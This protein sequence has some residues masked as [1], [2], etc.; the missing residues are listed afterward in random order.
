MA[1]TYVDLALASGSNNGTSWA[2]A[3][4]TTTPIQN[5]LTDAGA[6][7]RCFVKDDAGA[8]NPDTGTSR[9]LTS[10]A[11]PYNITQLI[12]CKSGT[13]A[14]PPTDADVC[15]RGTDNLRTFL[16]T[17]GI[18]RVDNELVMIGIKFDTATDVTLGSDSGLVAYDCEFE[19]GDDIDVTGNVRSSPFIAR[20]CE[21]IFAAAGSSFSAGAGNKI[22]IIGGLISGTAPTNLVVNSSGAITFYGVDLS[23][24]SGSTFV[25]QD[26]SRSPVYTRFI[27]CKFP[28]SYS[29][30]TAPVGS[31]SGFI[32]LIGCT[33]DTGVGTGESI[34]DY[35]REDIAG[36]LDHEVT[37]VR[38]GGANDGADG[39][40]SFALVP[41]VN[42]TLECV[43]GV[44]TPWLE[45]WIEG[46]GSTAYDVTVFIA[47][48]GGADY[49][50]DDIFFE[51]LSPDSAGTAQHNLSMIRDIISGSS[52]PLTDDTVSAWGTGG[53]NPQKI[54]Q[55]ITPD[56]SGPI[57][58]R[59]HFMK[60]FA[61]SPETLYVD[62]ILDIS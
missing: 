42:S 27:N 14:E 23:N 50:T 13:T 52:T 59:L 10:P 46:D 1:D 30:T 28:T 44:K 54:V 40:F 18:S 22:E 6:G 29:L 38:T 47:N 11:T 45:G 55:S 53:N 7:G 61:S 35:H 48:S 32:E 41:A 58:G 25:Y 20:N 15:V 26:T 49:N 24:A 62:P 9:A 19:F 17:T 60:R 43:Q 3:Y 8:T 12:G 33:D 5:G 39:A 2:N 57:Y 16:N 34:Q 4:H 51:L 56:F 36:T 37:A 31:L 21:F